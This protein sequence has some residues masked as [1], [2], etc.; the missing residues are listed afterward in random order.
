M[1]HGNVPRSVPPAYLRKKAAPQLRCGKSL[2]TLNIHNRAEECLVVEVGTITNTSLVCVNGVDGIIKHLADLVVVVDSQPDE[3]KNTQFRRKELI[4]L[5]CQFF[6]IPQEGIE[7]PNKIRENMQEGL[8]ELLV[9][10]S[11][12]V[13][14]IDVIRYDN[15]FICPFLLCFATDE[16]LITLQSGNEV[17]HTATLRTD[18]LFY[19][20]IGL[21]QFVVHTL[22]RALCLSDSAHAIDQYAYHDQ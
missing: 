20:A 6:P 16:A 8:V 12:A 9:K 4:P 21:Q 15:Q 3:S 7:V 1:L 22:D 17:R 18:I 2:K 14:R 11:S 13:V 10:V 19:D 5:N